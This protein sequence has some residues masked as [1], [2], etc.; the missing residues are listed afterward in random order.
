MWQKKL[1]NIKLIKKT[2]CL[3]CGNLRSPAGVESIFLCHAA[4]CAQAVLELEKACNAHFGFLDFLEFDFLGVSRFPSSNADPFAFIP[5]ISD[6]WVILMKARAQQYENIPGVEVVVTEEDPENYTI[7]DKDV[8][9]AEGSEA[10]ELNELAESGEDIECQASDMDSVKEEKFFKVIYGE[11][12]TEE[13]G[14]EVDG[15]PGISSG[16]NRT[17][18]TQAL[19]TLIFRYK[20]GHTYNILESVPQ[21]VQRNWLFLLDL[22][23]LGKPT[24]IYYDGLGMWD[25]NCGKVVNSFRYLEG[26]A[27]DAKDDKGDDVVQFVRRT[28]RNVN[29]KNFNRVVVICQKFQVAAVQY[30][31]KG[32]EE[33]AFEIANSTPKAIRLTTLNDSAARTPGKG[34]KRK[35]VADESDAIGEILYVSGGNQDP[36]RYQVIKAVKQ[37]YPAVS[38]AAIDQADPASLLTY[39]RTFVSNMRQERAEER[40]LRKEELEQRKKE[41][42]EE[43]EFRQQDL[44]LRR[45]ELQ[46]AMEKRKQEAAREREKEAI[47]QQHWDIERKQREID[48]KEREL[49]LEMLRKKMDT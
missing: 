25:Q 49:L 37:R 44:E 34:T 2:T 5:G 43:R 33:Q 10:S 40:Q 4:A 20:S 23:K 35:A 17:I 16:V 9:M 13:V 31:F 48:R 28:D 14:V 27:K 38:D 47:E 12:V 39:L 42:A 8:A 21:Q 46:E 24:D 3:R 36:T 22:R 41:R 19:A 45:K 32:C 6:V 18:P 7:T 26:E 1:K 30:F 15:H 29:F 11:V